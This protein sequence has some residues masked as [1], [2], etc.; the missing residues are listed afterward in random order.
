M[1]AIIML[2][3]EE[4]RNI[5]R[6]EVAKAVE[7]VEPNNELPHFLTREETKKLLRISETKMCELVGRTDFPVCRE[8]GVKIYT[9]ELFKW[10]RA[11]A[12]WIDKNAN[13]LRSIS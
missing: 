10:I 2:S 11:N 13:P 5:V 3:V 12:R 1:D 7:Q 8:F 4:L 9:E 6:E